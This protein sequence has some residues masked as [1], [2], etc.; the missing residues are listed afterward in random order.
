M[1]RIDLWAIHIGLKE[2]L[3]FKPQNFI[4]IGSRDGHDTKT[5]QEMFNI[6]PSNCYIFEAHPELS[7]LPILIV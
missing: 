4:E 2:V 6:P 7:N 1:A 3:N 5:I